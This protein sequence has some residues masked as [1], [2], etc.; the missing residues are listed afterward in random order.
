MIILILFIICDVLFIITLTNHDKNRNVY[1]I[2]TYYLELQ[3]MDFPLFKNI[4]ISQL[5]GRAI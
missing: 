2:F 3:S 1:I 4:V 5:R